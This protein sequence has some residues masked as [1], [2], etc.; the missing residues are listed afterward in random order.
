M[1]LLSQETLN[2]LDQLYSQVYRDNYSIMM[3]FRRDNLPVPQE[4][5]VA[6]EV[7]LGH[8]LLT[9][10]QALEAES[11]N[12]KLSVSHL[13]ELEALANEVGNQ[14]CG[15]R[16]LEVKE[17]LERL[18]VRSLRQILYEND[19]GNVE[20]DIYSLERIIDSGNQL[21]LG[22]SL[23]PAQEIYFQSLEHQIIPLCLGCIQRRNHT[24][25]EANAGD[26]ALETTW[27]LTQIRKLLQLGKK[28]AIDVD[29]WLN[30]L[31]R[32]SST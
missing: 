13:A 23:I 22:L 16:S 11:S 8:R 1:G 14:Q 15:S 4:L 7:A 19:H 6:A 27:E 5:Q 24:Q 28:L 26:T 20:E 17:A 30:Q 2:R 10:V 18:I 31:Y 25:V 3:A 21:N 32:K 12:G 29:Q 9:S